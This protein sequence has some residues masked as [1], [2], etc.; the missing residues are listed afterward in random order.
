MMKTA[1]FC[2]FALAMTTH[3]YASGGAGMPAS[4]FSPTELC[5]GSGFPQQACQ[6]A[7]T[8]QMIGFNS[9]VLH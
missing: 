2:C 5:T 3:Y 8:G 4:R 7:R 1:Y 6:H 9:F